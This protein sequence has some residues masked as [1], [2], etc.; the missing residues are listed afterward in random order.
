MSDSFVEE[1]SM[2][3]TIKI[4]IFVILLGILNGCSGE[5]APKAGNESSQSHTIMTAS[6]SFQ[7]HSAQIESTPAPSLEAKTSERTS[8]PA[9]NPGGFF[10]RKNFTRIDSNIGKTYPQ[11][12]G[13]IS[14]E[15]LIGLL[16][17]SK[18]YDNWEMLL[19]NGYVI[20]YSSEF[21]DS[22]KENLTVDISYFDYSKNFGT[23]LSY[24]RL[25][26]GEYNVLI[27]FKQ[28]T[29]NILD[30][31]SSKRTILDSFQLSDEYSWK[32]M[33]L[34]KGFTRDGQLA[35]AFYSPD[36]NSIYAVNNKMELI[37]TIPLDNWKYIAAYEQINYNS[38][39]DE[40]YVYATDKSEETL[41]KIRVNDSKVIYERSI[42]GKITGKIQTIVSN[43]TNE[44]FMLT[45]DAQTRRNE[46]YFIRESDYGNIGR[47]DG[48]FSGVDNIY[49]YS[50][51]PQNLFLI[52]YSPDKAIPVDKM[53]AFEN[54]IDVFP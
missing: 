8:L 34:I 53:Y 30:Y 29:I 44:M 39:D 4:S 33:K 22:Y 45:Y 40:L 24:S 37:Q 21:I 25:L 17:G 23:D 36:N 18:A 2:E 47:K 41:R 38:T 32:N 51:N 43:N 52:T 14:R 5:I 7:S 26:D 16:K 1:Q 19:S 48:H 12:F 15:E 49:Y 3:A 50:Q 35:M 9:A 20:E 42:A 27:D 54:L 10:S 28:N 31:G 13:H 11:Q 46:I 6:P